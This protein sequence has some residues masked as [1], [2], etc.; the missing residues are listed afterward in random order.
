[1]PEPFLFDKSNTY[2]D[3]YNPWYWSGH[4]GVYGVWNSVYPPINFIFLK[5][6]ELFSGLNVADFSNP[7]ELRAAFGWKISFVLLSYILLLGL[8]V[9]KS[10]SLLFNYQELGVIFLISLLSPPALFALERGNLIFFSLYIF[11]VYVWAGNK[12]IKIIAFSIL[13]N[14]K[15]YFLIIYIIEI[16]RKD[17]DKDFLFIAPILSIIIFVGF[18][19]LLNQEYYLILRNLIGFADNANFSGPEI[20]SFPISLIAFSKFNLITNINEIFELILII[21]KILVFIT[22]ILI[23]IEIS[24]KGISNRDFF[25]L[26]PLFI[27]NYSVSS[28]GYSA[29]YYL[30]VISLLLMSKAYNILALVLGSMFIGIWDWFPIM[31]LGVWN[32]DIYLSGVSNLVEVSLG[33]GSLLRPICNFLSLLFFYKRLKINYAN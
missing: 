11:S 19:F 3:F 23:F 5:L 31:P 32:F 15:P 16:I 30:P 13:V 26:I 2:M 6:Y 22:I 27:T 4:D 8:T 33:S 14:I 18:G 7:D 20:F 28:G 25:I 10:F 24:I 29:L 12:L 17:K 21:P 1:M 9:K